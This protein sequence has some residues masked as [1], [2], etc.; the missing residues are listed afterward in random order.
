L[1]G[2]EGAAGAQEENG[3]GGY[4]YERDEGCGGEDDA[5][6]ERGR[7]VLLSEGEGNESGARGCGGG[8]CRVCAVVL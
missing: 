4:R 5:E 2:V 7:V 8:H 6:G 1:E 3:E